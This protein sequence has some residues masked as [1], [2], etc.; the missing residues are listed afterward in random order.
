MYD[1]SSSLFGQC[2]HLRNIFVNWVFEKLEDEVLTWI[3]I[4]GRGSEEGIATPVR[5]IDLEMRR[6]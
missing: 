5:I 3:G 4:L 1:C 2:Q 6:G